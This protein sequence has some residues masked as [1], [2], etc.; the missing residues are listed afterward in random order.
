MAYMELFV[1][2]GFALLWAV[3]ELV[4]LRLDKQRRERAARERDGA[5]DA[6]G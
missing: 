3:L 2:L 6:M 5:G 4:G 1:V